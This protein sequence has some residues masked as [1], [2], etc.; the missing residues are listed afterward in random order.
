MVISY[1]ESN[2]WCELIWVDNDHFRFRFYNKD[3]E[4]KSGAVRYWYIAMGV[5]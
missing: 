3:G 5:V 1:H 4:I 2:V